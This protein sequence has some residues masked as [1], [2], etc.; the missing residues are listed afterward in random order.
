MQKRNGTFGTIIFMIAL[1]LLCIYFCAPW[2]SQSDTLKE[3][4]GRQTSEA[5][6]LSESL[7]LILTGDLMCQWRQQNIYYDRKTDTYDFNPQ[8]D[9]VRD[10]LK[11]ADLTIGNLETNLSPSEPLGREKRK[12]YG[13][14]YLNAPVEFL[15][16]LKNAGFDILV[17]ANNHNADTGIRGMQETLEAQEKYGFFH[18]G[19]FAD[20]EEKRF[21]LFEQNGIKLGIASYSGFYNRSV[22]DF[23]TEQQNIHLNHYAQKKM[24]RDLSAMRKQGAEYIIVYYHDGTEYSHRPTERQYQHVQEIADAGAD[25]VVVSHAHTVQPCAK[26]TSED[27]RT[28]PV[29][30]GIGNFVSHMTQKNCSYGM[31]I[32]IT[33]KKEK[34]RTVLA[35]E[36]YYPTY[37]L[38]KNRDTGKNFQVIPCTKEGIGAIRDSKQKEELI[39]ARRLILDVTGNSITPEE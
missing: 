8:L 3:K 35:E 26:I 37:L 31:M 34:G 9:Y 7:N 39:A 4:G 14:Y 22:R 13:I 15:D 24:C 16:T 28:V 11:S 32:S 36:S 38:K 30:Y 12:K 2:N 21:L 5:E 18:T 25:Y 19:L 27:G 23:S 10:I 1:V 17:N 29:A 6:Q 20:S 33:L